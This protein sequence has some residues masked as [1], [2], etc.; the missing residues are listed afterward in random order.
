[1]PPGDARVYAAAEKLAGTVPEHIGLGI[2]IDNPGHCGEWASR[3]FSLQCVSF[4]G[5]M[6]AN[7][8]RSVVEQARSGMVGRKNQAG[9]TE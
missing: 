2:Y 3:R 5:R 6:L 9:N 7:G 4:D 1:V 8:A